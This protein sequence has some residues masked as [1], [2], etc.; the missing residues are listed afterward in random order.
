[1]S[2]GRAT[3]LCTRPALH[4]LHGVSG[5]VPRLVNMIAHRALLAAFVARE[6][7]VTRRLIAR[8]YREIQAV[9]LPGTLTLARKAA[10]A[11]AGLAIGAALVAFGAPELD[12]LLGPPRSGAGG[13]PA[14]AGDR[15]A[16]EPPAAPDMA[17]RSAAAAPATVSAAL[18]PAIIP[19]TS[20]AELAKRVAGVD[21]R[22][23]ARNA[24]A[25]VL[26]AWNER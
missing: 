8:A 12:R 14:R 2:G 16:P 13:A 22:T 1:A 25:A 20:A 18:A 15:P 5:G 17:P 24:T 19:P 3:R 10:L 11:G 4:L 6:P 21:V 9:P 7:R 23:S 26:A